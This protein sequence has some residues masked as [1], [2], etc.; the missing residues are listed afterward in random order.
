MNN[1]SITT[2]SEQPEVESKQKTV[3]KNGMFDL[4]EARTL[5]K[6]LKQKERDNTNKTVQSKINEKSQLKGSELEVFKSEV[7]NDVTEE[8]ENKQY[9]LNREKALRKKLAASNYEEL[10]IIHTGGGVKLQMNAGMY[11]LFKYAAQNY[12]TSEAMVKKTIPTNVI[13]KKQNN[14][15]TRYKIS[16][17]K[18]SHYTLNLYHTTSSVLVNG[19][20]VNQFLN[21][22]VTE[23][24][25]SLER[26]IA[27]NDCSVNNF[28]KQIKKLIISSLSE[29]P[30]S[31]HVHDQV[32]V[33]EVSDTDTT[34]NTEDESTGEISEE[35]DSNS[36]DRELEETTEDE[37]QSV[38]TDYLSDED[39]NHSSKEVGTEA[40]TILKALQS[41]VSE[42]KNL[43]LSHIE[44]THSNFGRLCDE[45]VSIKKQVSQRA[46]STDSRIETV[47]QDVHIANLDL[48]KYSDSLQRRLQAV[49][50]IIKSRQTT[51]KN[52]QPLPSKPQNVEMSDQPQRTFDH[53]ESPG[54]TLLL[55]D[56]IFRDI[57]AKGLSENTEIRT[58]SGGKVRQVNARLRQW[59]VAD[60]GSVVIYIGG[61]D[62]A[63]DEKE[64]SLYRQLEE[65]IEAVRRDNPYCEIYI[66]TVCPRT[67]CNVRELN[68]LLVK[69]SENTDVNLIQSYDKFVYGD[70]STIQDY[71][72]PDGIH[73]NKKGTSILVKTID[74]SI[75]IVRKSSGNRK[76]RFDAN[77]SSQSTPRRDRYGHSEEHRGGRRER[78][79][80]GELEYNTYQNRQSW[81][82][83]RQRKW[84][85]NC[86]MT[87]HNTVDCGTRREGNRN[88]QDAEFAQTGRHNTGY[89]RRS[90][91]SFRRYH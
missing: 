61:N 69:L 13:D 90:P 71:Y 4:D 31:S 53:D 11:E 79:Y 91:D 63:S 77:V 47:Q 41:E 65:G 43:L 2:E 84:C 21:T 48:K 22:D 82:S 29:K 27:E 60:L 88:W 57:Q 12:Y 73:L 54:K 34:G 76:D 80:S 38:E 42:L 40:I 78:R 72:H 32:N 59:L 56:S 20:G 50:D 87:N 62:V 8:T 26:N 23:I 9:E 68:K 74:K 14:V 17:G 67:D 24:L 64:D 30:N 39:K 86:R 89:H 66:C 55:G 28:N 52:Q 46:S 51:T 75:R 70:G 45:I 37:F 81:N 1:I 44:S 6:M 5:R 3:T 36:E 58:I 7:Q 18:L 35:K 10:S 16:T 15:E 33:T 25:S 19:K 83:N 85:T 49:M